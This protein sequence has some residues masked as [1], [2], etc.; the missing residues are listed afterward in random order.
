MLSFTIYLYYYSRPT[1]S[2][3]DETRSRVS[4]SMYSTYVYALTGLGSGYLT[5]LERLIY[6]SSVG[7]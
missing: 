2:G 1:R 4:I 7:T 3:V 6:S 5:S